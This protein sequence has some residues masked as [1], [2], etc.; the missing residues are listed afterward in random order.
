MPSVI[1]V[2]ADTVS[3][4][5]GMLKKWLDETPGKSQTWLAAQF[6]I[7]QSAVAKWI[8]FRVPAERVKKVS[9]LTGIPPEDLRPDVF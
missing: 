2:F 4:D 5:C 3:Y 8:K 9:K 1:I 6:G 7:R